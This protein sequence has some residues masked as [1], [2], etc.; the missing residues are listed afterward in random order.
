MAVSISTT[1]ATM[2]TAASDANAAVDRWS[3]AYSAND[4][5]TIAKNYCRDA[6]LLKTVSRAGEQEVLAIKLLILLNYSK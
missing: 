5:E 1:H 6:I 2:R 4:P 3:A